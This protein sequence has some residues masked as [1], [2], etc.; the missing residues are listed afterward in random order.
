MH[1]YNDDNTC[2]TFIKSDVLYIP[3]HK[4]KLFKEQTQTSILGAVHKH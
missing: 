4:V 2:R 1:S 3:R